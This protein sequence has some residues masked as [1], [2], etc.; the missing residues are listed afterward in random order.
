MASYRIIHYLG[1]A[2]LYFEFEI[3]IRTRQKFHNFGFV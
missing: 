3:E 1:A 2:L